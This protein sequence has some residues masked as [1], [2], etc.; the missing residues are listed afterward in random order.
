[1]YA[2]S[3]LACVLACL[4]LVPASA[5]ATMSFLGTLHTVTSL[6]STVPGNGDV[7]PYGIVTVPR[8]SGSLVRG[9]ILIS[10]FNNFEN[11]QG[12]GSTIVEKTPQGGLSLFAH[13][14]SGHL[15]GP[16]PGG[17]GL[18]TALAI[19]P[20]NFVVVGSLPSEDGKAATSE[21][22]CLIVIDPNGKPVETISGGQINGPWDMTEAHGPG[23]TSLFVTNVLNG[24][25]AHGTMPTPE[26][27]VVRLDLRIPPGPPAPPDPP[28]HPGPHM[29]MGPPV[30]PG[31]HPPSA[32]APSVISEHVIATG[33]QE[34][35]SEEAFVLGPTGV[36]LGHGGILYVADTFSSRI[37]AV[38]DALTRT[39]A[40]PNGGTT[41]SEGEPLNAPLGMTIA[42]NGDVLTANG[43]DGNLVETTPQGTHFPP[44]ETGLKGGALFGLTLTPD[45][46]G[47][48]FVN[49]EENVL[50]LLH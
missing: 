13:L 21:P 39:S 7:N 36:G 11:L 48:Y 16:C 35:A 45:N 4:L 26:G 1:V 40:A 6:E 24:N 31:P 15:A 29:R 41:V 22:G 2:L 14:E 43:G 33:F 42:P 8:T 30:P 50:D 32:M 37:A 10:N 9:D 5:T 23:H 25:V 49:D 20:D 28:V 34:Q 3:A 38:P 19:L 12:T 44:F 17:V 46:H 47:I 18:T 27:T